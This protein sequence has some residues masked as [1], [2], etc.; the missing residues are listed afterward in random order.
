MWRG[1]SQANVPQMDHTLMIGFAPRGWLAKNADFIGFLS[2][3]SW[4]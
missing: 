3:L 1:N 4:L 2:T